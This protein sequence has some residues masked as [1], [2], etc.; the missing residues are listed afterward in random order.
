MATNHLSTKVSEKQPSAS[1]LSGRIATL[2]SHYYDPKHGDLLT[3]AA[4]VDWLNILS[5]FPQKA[6]EHACD[7]YMRNVTGKRPTPAEIR[8]RADAWLKANAPKKC[9]GDRSTLSFDELEKLEEVLA[10]AR[11]WL[12]NPNLKDHGRKT[13]EYWGEHV[14]EPVASEPADFE[15]VG[16]I[17][18]AA[19]FNP[20]R[21][22]LVKRFP[23]ATSFKQAENFA[24]SGTPEGLRPEQYMTEA[25]RQERGMA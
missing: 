14:P 7:H 11:R 15:S 6:I 20:E 25:E 18:D 17:M 12:S 22:N 13:L 23:K 9:Q 16:R 24:A 2:L 5:P 19:G 1:W 8:N 4:A 3:E 10:T 21:M